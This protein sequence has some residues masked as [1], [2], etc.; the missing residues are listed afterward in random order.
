MIF[1]I[2]MSF[3]VV[4]FQNAGFWRL[5][6]PETSIWAPEGAFRG[7]SSRLFKFSILLRRGPG[8][9][10]GDRARAWA[11]ACEEGWKMFFFVQHGFFEP[12]LHIFGP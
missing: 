10:P 7:F 4:D 5:K 9:G 6:A 2:S 11:G 3:W 12:F 1:G 8:L